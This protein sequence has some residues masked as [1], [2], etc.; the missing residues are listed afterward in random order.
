[1]MPIDLKLQVYIAMI[2]VF[3]GAIDLG[4][5]GLAGTDLISS[6]LGHILGRLIFIVIGAAAGYLIYLK[7][8]K[9]V[10]LSISK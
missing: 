7:F 1:M 4:I 8:M 6:I 5:F 9:K 10:D 2:L 3:V